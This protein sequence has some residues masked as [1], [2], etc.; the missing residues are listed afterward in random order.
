VTFLKSSKSEE[1]SGITALY[2]AAVQKIP[3]ELIVDYQVYLHNRNIREEGLKELS[4]VSGES[5]N[6]PF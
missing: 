2:T 3:E 5:N 6:I 4:R 1:L